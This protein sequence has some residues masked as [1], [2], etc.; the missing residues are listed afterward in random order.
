MPLRLA[1]FDF[2]QTLTTVHLFNAL[3]GDEP[4]WRLPP[5]H[6]T[7]ESGQ[8]VRLSELEA[9]PEFRSQGGLALAAFGGS[10]R[11]SSLHGLLRQLTSAG[12]ECII[13]SKGL[14]GPVRKCLD[15][16]GLLAFFSK[17]YANVGGAYGSLLYDRQL[18]PGAVGQ[19]S[20]Y[21]GSPDLADWQNNK[22]ALI[23][24]CLRERGLHGSEAV[25]VDDQP[26]E[27]ESLRNVCPTV[28][29]QSQRGIGPR[30]LELLRSL[31]AGGGSA[32][33]GGMAA[34]GERGRA[35]GL[36]HGV[37]QPPVACDRPSSSFG[38]AQCGS[39]SSL[40]RQTSRAGPP[41]PPPGSARRPW[42]SQTGRRGR[43]RR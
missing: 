6:A 37:S 35:G 12:V 23:S 27:V 42:P 17:V 8:L 20:R 5:P 9:L 33:C 29:V 43:R 40:H 2:D 19:D 10:E 18:P 4:S 34:P 31:L 3:A 14:V 24:R 13:C 11:V 41:P 16:V 30:E 25:F 22:Q 38:E 26:S 7:T 1:V 39:G 28:H 32:G 36:V 21:L 15:H